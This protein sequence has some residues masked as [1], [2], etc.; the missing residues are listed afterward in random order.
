MPRNLFDEEEKLSRPSHME[1]PTYIYII[2]MVYHAKDPW[3]EVTLVLNTQHDLS[4][5][6]I[7]P[8][9]S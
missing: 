9:P 3:I 8:M 5:K 2:F 4:W 7:K 6:P 1:S